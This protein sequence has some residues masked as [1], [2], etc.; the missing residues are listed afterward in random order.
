MSKFLLVVT[1]GDGSEETVGV[2]EAEG[3]TD[4]EVAG[5]AFVAAMNLMEQEGLEFDI[6]AGDT[7]TLREID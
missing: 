3:R 6:D 2:V 1:R 4:G 7:F 5:G